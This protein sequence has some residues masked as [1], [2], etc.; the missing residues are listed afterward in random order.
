MSFTVIKGILAAKVAYDAI[1]NFLAFWNSDEWIIDQF[2][3]VPV[4]KEQEPELC[5]IVEQLAQKAGVPTPRVFV[6]ADDFPNACATGRDAEHAAIVVTTAL[7]NTADFS[8]TQLDHEELEGIL[9]HEMSH[10]KNKDVMV[11]T[12]AAFIAGALTSL[13]PIGVLSAKDV[14]AKS[15][16]DKSLIGTGAVLG[17]ALLAE[18]MQMAVSKQ[19]EYN[20]DESAGYL[21]GKPDA[22]AEALEKI[23]RVGKGLVTGGANET[24]SH[25]FTIN[26]FGKEV[27]E[28]FSTHPSIE[29]RV[30]RLR[31]QAL[32]LGRSI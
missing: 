5:G 18:I 4:T 1:A 26:P 2:K 21:T 6:Y 25:L 10:I 31:Q 3:A 32:A 16:R 29:D 28:M 8:E 12:A 11:N 27:E 15:N 19:R 22:L 9:A 17:T 14:D 7:K 24:N 30:A 23:D 20:A 13:V